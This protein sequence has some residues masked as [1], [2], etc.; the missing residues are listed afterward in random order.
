M[1]DKWMTK[2]NFEIAI[3]CHKKE[4]PDCKNCPFNHKSPDQG[5]KKIYC[6]GVKNSPE[7]NRNMM[8]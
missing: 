3:L 4:P 7:N 6:D 2:E 1:N 5:F 8:R